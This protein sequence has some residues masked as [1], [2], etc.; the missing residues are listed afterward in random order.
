ML[1]CQWHVG[2]TLSFLEISLCS[3]TLVGLYITSTWD[4]FTWKWLFIWLLSRWSW[5]Q[6]YKA[7]ILNAKKK[8][9]NFPMV[10]LSEIS[11]KGFKLR[12]VSL[13]IFEN[14]ENR[15]WFSAHYK[16]IIIYNPVFG[17]IKISMILYIG[18]R[19]NLNNDNFKF[20]FC[21][22][23]SKPH[24]VLTLSIGITLSQ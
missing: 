21:I 15:S 14:I 3:L 8:S 20:M 17:P 5:D 11:Y 19:T 23:W 22:T 16:Y 12:N 2:F 18:R 9:M 1:Y 6:K 7:V 4:D 10:V 24:S 13:A